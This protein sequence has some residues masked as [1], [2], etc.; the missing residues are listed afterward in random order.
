[1]ALKSV[2]VFVTIA[3]ASD[4]SRSAGGELGEPLSFAGKS[5]AE[6]LVS[7]LIGSCEGT[8]SW[9]GGDAAEWVEAHR[10][11]SRDRFTW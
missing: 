4:E 8:D 9:G 5:A 3:V 6:I 11:A 2:D 1:M 7:G 10:Q